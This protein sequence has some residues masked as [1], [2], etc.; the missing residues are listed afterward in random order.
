MR[1]FLLL[2]AEIFFAIFVFAQDQAFVYN[3][4]GRRDPFWRLVTTGG[5]IL[6]YDKNLVI[7]DMTLEGISYDAGGQSMAIINGMI[8]KRDDRMG[9]YTI[10]KIDPKKVTLVKEQETFVL[11][12]KKE[13]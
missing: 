11:E 10:T 8:F 3:D 13:E 6:N 7:A 1:V 9:V 12:L 4:H 5:V 2:I